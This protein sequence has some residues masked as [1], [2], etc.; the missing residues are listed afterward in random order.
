MAIRDRHFTTLVLKG[1]SCTSACAYAFL[2][3]KVRKVDFGASLGLHR[4]YSMNFPS[5]EEAAHHNQEKL[6]EITEVLL[7][8]IKSMNVDPQIIV[9]AQAT[10]PNEMLY[11]QGSDM[12]A[13]G[14]IT[15]P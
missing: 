13:L 5:G 9:L 10:D 4:F 6:D 15:E 7:G 1:A 14:F 2:G 11:L 8:Y 12:L 3:G